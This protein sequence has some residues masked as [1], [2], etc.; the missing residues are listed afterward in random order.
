MSRRYVRMH[1]CSLSFPSGPGFL[2]GVAIIPKWHHE[3]NSGCPVSI[4][5]VV[6]LPERSKGADA[7]FPIVTEI[8]C[9]CFEIRAV[10]VA[11]KDHSLIVGATVCDYRIA[12]FIDDLLA[13]F[14]FNLAAVITKIEIKFPIGTEHKRMNSMVVLFSS[15]TGEQNFFAIGFGITIGI[16]QV[17]NSI[18]GRS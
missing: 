5:V 17:K 6:G 15:D 7:N 2:I 1:A 12:R 3:V 14:I 10:E 18:V 16:N 9:E 4:I 13:I 8:P 11:S